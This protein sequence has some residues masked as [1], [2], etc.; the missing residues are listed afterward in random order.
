MSTIP[1]DTG[2]ILQVKQVLSNMELGQ[3][4]DAIFIKNFQLRSSWKVVRSSAMDS[5]ITRKGHSY[6]NS[7]Q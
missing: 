1:A 5:T 7:A 4:V 3:P 6:K 2:P